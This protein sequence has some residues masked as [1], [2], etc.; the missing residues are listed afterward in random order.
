MDALFV[1]SNDKSTSE[2]S[3]KQG[4]KKVLFWYTVGTKNPD[5]ILATGSKNEKCHVEYSY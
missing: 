3:S 4:I 5:I 1:L 2:Y